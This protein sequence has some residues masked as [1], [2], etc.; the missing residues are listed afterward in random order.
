MISEGSCDIEVMFTIYQIKAALVIIR[1]FFQKH[2][3]LLTL[4]FVEQ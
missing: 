1:N 2:K 3:K 4:N